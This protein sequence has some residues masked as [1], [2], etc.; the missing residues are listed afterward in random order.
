L[1]RQFESLRPN[2]VV[3]PTLFSIV[4]SQRHTHIEKLASTL[5]FHFCF[6]VGSSARSGGLGVFC[7]IGINLDVTGFWEYHID[8]RI[9]MTRKPDCPTTYGLF[10]SSDSE[11]F[12]CLGLVQIAYRLQSSTLDLYRRF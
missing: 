8:A 3:C 6:G 7:N 9:S 10:Q 11:R 2:E 12:G 4:E 5:G 1:P